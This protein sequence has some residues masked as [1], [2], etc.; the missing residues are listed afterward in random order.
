MADCTAPLR[1]RTESRSSCANDLQLL[2]GI[3]SNLA[4]VPCIL[5]F[6]KSEKE[7]KWPPELDPLYYNEQEV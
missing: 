6:V 5:R 3:E 4:G 2:K 7:R 1:P